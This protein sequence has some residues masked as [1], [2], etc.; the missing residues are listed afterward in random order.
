MPLILSAEN[1]W[2]NPYLGGLL[3]PKSLILFLVGSRSASQPTR[4]TLAH[5]GKEVGR[6]PEKKTFYITRGC[7]GG[8]FGCGC[9]LVLPSRTRGGA[10]RAEVRSLAPTINTRVL[11]HDWSRFSRAEK[12]D[13]FSCLRSFFFWFYFGV[14]GFT[15]CSQQSPEPN[16]LVHICSHHNQVEFR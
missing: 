1:T 14:F 5:V 10:V 7:L 3:L 8:R 15:T 6:E 12:W 9:R 13:C 16:E 4:T 2:E 11:H